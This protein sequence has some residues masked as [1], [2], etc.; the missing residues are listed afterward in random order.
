MILYFTAS[1]NS[2]AVAQVIA[3]KTG[4]CIFD[5]G[6][7]YREGRFEVEID[8]GEDL[9]IVFPVYR[10]S[11]PSVVDKFLRKARFFT[12]DG[13]QF[14]PGYCYVV[15]TYG[16][17]TGGETAYLKKE[18]FETINA[19]V[20]AEFAV[21]ANENCVYVSN[22][23]TPEKAARRNAQMLED[24]AKVAE[25]IAMKRRGSRIK[26]TVPG[27]LMSKVTGTNEKKRSL[28]HY[29]VIVERCIGCG[30]CAAVCPMGSIEMVDGLPKWNGA[31]CCECLACLHRCPK[32][33]SQYGRIS[34][35][36]RRYL[37]PAINGVE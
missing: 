6:K 36:R 27:R 5:L 8:Q 15:E 20:D 33:A 35:K 30:T 7:A 4:D 28:S 2:L 13:S 31:E 34:R 24:A 25:A 26:G 17:F 19:M 11:T 1:G 10:W 21:R 32:E 12:P 22:P 16:Y 18:V 14:A 29:N 9:G 23:P 37:N 3:E